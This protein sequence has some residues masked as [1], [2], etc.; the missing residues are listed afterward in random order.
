[1]MF[2]VV[3]TLVSIYVRNPSNHEVILDSPKRWEHFNFMQVRSVAAFLSIWLYVIRKIKPC[4]KVS[5]LQVPLSNFTAT[6]IR[7]QGYPFT[8]HVCIC[9]ILFQRA[10]LV[11]DFTAPR[12]T[13][14]HRG[15]VIRRQHPAC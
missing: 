4:L 9:K 5:A 11:I 1:M 7:F 3:M 8:Y 12:S 15:T 14:G 10:Y 6:S 13:L 2:T